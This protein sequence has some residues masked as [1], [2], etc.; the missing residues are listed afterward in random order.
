MEIQKF[1]NLMIKN[2][3]T[4]ACDMFLRYM[5]PRQSRIYYFLRSQDVE[6]NGRVVM[7]K[8]E[9]F[10]F[11]DVNEKEAKTLLTT[12][13]KLFKLLFRH[14]T[15]KENELTI[16]LRSQYDIAKSLGIESF[17][18][19]AFAEVELQDILD[20]PKSLGIEMGVKYHQH[21]THYQLKH[22]SEIKH[23]KKQVLPLNFSSTSNLAQG[24][25]EYNFKNNTPN[26]LVLTDDNVVSYGTSQSKLA[27]MLNVSL[28]TL[29][30]HLKHVSKLKCFQKVSE[31]VVFCEKHLK[32]DNYFFFFKWLNN[33]V[34]PLPNIYLN[35]IVFKTKRMFKTKY[36]KYILSA[37]ES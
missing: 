31:H 36:N 3:T 24:V 5:T 8:E 33:Y 35:D 2:T 32:T 6:G 16:Y 23:A 12:S 20:S 17:K 1:E 26:A 10:K 14:I 28:S 11:L 4:V 7:S 34:K 30:R 25:T 29:K 13:G 9:L 22:D 19:C 21:K 15:W 37:V 27:N 18:S